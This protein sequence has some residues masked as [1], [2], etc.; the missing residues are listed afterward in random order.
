M[1]NPANQNKRKLPPTENTR[2][3][4]TSSTNAGRIKKTRGN[5]KSMEIL[6]D[7]ISYF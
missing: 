5:N 4:P 1:R 7:L 2:G 3:P 6:L